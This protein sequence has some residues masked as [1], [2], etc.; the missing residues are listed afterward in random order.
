MHRKFSYLLRKHAAR[1]CPT[2]LAPLNG[3]M[4]PCSNQTGQICQFSCNTGYM[5]SGSSVRT[6]L[7]T[8]TWSGSVF[9]CQPRT[10]NPLEAPENGA[11]LPPCNDEFLSVCTPLCNFGYTLEGPARQTCI[12]N[13][14]DEPV[15]T[16][17]PMCKGRECMTVC[18]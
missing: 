15:W 9:T 5:L 11:V 10:C 8:S 6:C 14:S 2:L 1:Q 12:L 18:I 3:R 16:E 17:T 13:M 7:P 4:E